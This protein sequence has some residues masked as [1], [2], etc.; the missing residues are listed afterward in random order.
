MAIFEKVSIVGRKKFEDVIDGNSGAD[1]IN[2]TSQS[3]AFFLHDALSGF[4]SSMSLSKDAFG[5]FS[6]PI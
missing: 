5:N 4:H 6:I 3:D 1:T 2:L